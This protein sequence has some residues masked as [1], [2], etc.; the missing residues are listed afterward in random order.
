MV[1]KSRVKNGRGGGRG[2]QGG[3]GGEISQRGKWLNGFLQTEEKMVLPSTILTF[4]FEFGG[5]IV[6]AHCLPLSETESASEEYTTY[7]CDGDLLRLEC[8]SQSD[9]IRVTRANYGRDDKNWLFV[10][11]NLVKEE[12]RNMIKTVNNLQVLHRGVQ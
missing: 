10:D 12:S 7:A 4:T 3:M 6:L 11:L 1:E 5:S 8:P 9:V 2:R